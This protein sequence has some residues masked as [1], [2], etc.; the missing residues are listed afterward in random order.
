[1]EVCVSSSSTFYVR[2]SALARVRRFLINV[3]SPCCAILR[4]FSLES[5]SLRVLHHMFVPCLS[6]SATTPRGFY[7]FPDPSSLLPLPRPPE[8]S[9]SA[10]TPR[11]F[12]LCHDP[13]SLIHQSLY[14]P[15]PSCQPPPFTTYMYTRSTY[16]ISAHTL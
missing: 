11:A 3:S 7:V 12:Y 14:M 16:T 9:T 5:K 10:T 4:H 1:M 13:S 2:V 15:T 6:T 8:L